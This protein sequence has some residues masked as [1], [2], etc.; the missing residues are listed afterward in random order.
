MPPA[1]SA[2][3]ATGASSNQRLGG[4]TWDALAEIRSWSSMPLVLKGIL[5]VDDARRAVD[6][7]VDAI[8]V[9]THGGRQLDRSI[10]SADAL[11][12]SSM[13]SPGRARSGSTAGS[14]AG[15]TS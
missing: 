13:R 6:A 8:V 14:A 11:G 1:A 4:L 15:S 3:I 2:T 7:G 12:R 10:A 9:S 5:A